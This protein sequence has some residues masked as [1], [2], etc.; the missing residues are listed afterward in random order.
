MTS[1]SP[2]EHDTISQNPSAKVPDPASS[3]SNQ[4]TQD[5]PATKPEKAKGA[6]VMTAEI[7]AEIEAAM[8]EMNLEQPSSEAGPGAGPRSGVAATRFPPAQAGA[9]G[10]ANPQGG[11]APAKVRGPRVVQAGREHRTGMVVSVGPTDIFI[12]FGPKELGVLERTQFKDDELPTPGQQLEVVITRYEAQ[13]SLYICIRPGAV[14]KADWEMLEAGQLVDGIVTGVNKGGLEMEVAHRRAFMPASQISFE[15]IEDLT[16][17]IGQKLQCKVSRVDRSGKG[18]IVLSRRD[19]LNEERK[20]N[21][22]KIREKL[23]EGDTVEGTVRKIMPFGAFVDLGG[24]DGLV[25]VSDLTHDR[26]GMGERAVAKYVS[27]GQT[28]RVQILKLDWEN[29]RISLGIKQLMSDPFQDAGSALTEGEIVT[30]RVTK[31][32]EFGA[33]VEIAPGVE[34]LVHI[35]ELDWRRVNTVDEVVKQG[36]VITVKVLRVDPN[37]RKVSLSLKQAKERPEQPAREGSSAQAAPADAKPVKTPK[38]V[39]PRDARGGGKGERDTRS[40][41]EILKETPALRRLREQGK[42]KDKKLSGGGLG[43]AGG[44]G[45][46]L[47]DLKL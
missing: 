17:F 9:A 7:E 6:P 46:G 47:G 15:R 35:S 34:G 25:H 11:V 45:M 24:I 28:V 14:E 40:P 36:E 13:E 4:S 2:T 38:G 16:P 1:P 23:K 10:G 8:E 3:P 42:M 26:V 44:L 33:F 22:G 27:E 18:N 21:A 30:G 29:E 41:E 19:L 37:D 31:V 20:A 39:K 12:E 43:N 32:L 5:S